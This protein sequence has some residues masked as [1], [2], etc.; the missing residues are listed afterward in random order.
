MLWPPDADSL[1]KTD[2]GKDRKQREQGVAKY[3]MVK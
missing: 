3:E 2:A 1:G